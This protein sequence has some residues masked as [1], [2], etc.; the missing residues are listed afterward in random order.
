[1]RAGRNGQLR[2]ETH[3]AGPCRTGDGKGGAPVDRTERRDAPALAPTLLFHNRPSIE[4]A[5]TQSLP[6]H[7]GQ[8]ARVASPFSAGTVA[9]TSVSPR[10]TSSPALPQCFEDGWGFVRHKETAEILAFPITCG[11]WD[12]PDCAQRKLARLTAQAFAGEPNKEFMLTTLPDSSRSRIEA[13]RHY[14][15]KVALLVKRIRRTWGPFEYFV[16]VEFTKRGAVH[17]HG[18]ARTGYIA[19]AWLSR[20]WKQLTG[21][22][23]VWIKAIKKEASAVLHAVKYCLKTA[24]EVSQATPGFRPVTMS[25]SWLPDDWHA[26]DAADSDFEFVGF[27]RLAGPDF[28][29]ALDA[30]GFEAVPSPSLQGGLVLRARGPPDREALDQAR[31]FGSSGR[32]KLAAL[33]L[34]TVLRP[35]A[36]RVPIEQLRDE[37]DFT[38]DP[39]T[40]F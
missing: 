9:G 10:P 30:F 8:G 33:L 26:K 36:R 23:V 38:G 29:G 7:V 32:R 28:Y 20:N 27:L 15:P 31:C 14:R 13:V 18:L 35:Q 11:R 16:T 17:F 5:N 1:M 6:L 2:E 4:Q 24:A 40:Q 39:R 12:C 37:M 25:G 22:E 3:R 19:Q 21:A 34:C